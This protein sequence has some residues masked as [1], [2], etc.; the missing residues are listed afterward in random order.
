MNW[1][2]QLPLACAILGLGAA[3]Y[4][5]LWLHLRAADDG[6]YTRPRQPLDTLPLNFTL[7]AATPSE[8]SRW[9]G[10]RH[11]GT[12]AVRKQV[13]FADEVLYRYYSLESSGPVVVVYL[14][15]SSSG[16]DR[17][18]HP[19]ICMREALGVPEDASGRTLVTL[20]GQSRQAQRF[21]FVPGSGRQVMIYYWH[22]TLP[23]C[24]AGG[25]TWIQALHRRRKVSPPSVT[26]QVSTDA[27]PDQ[28][29]AVEKGFLPALDAA[30]RTD[31]LPEGTTVG[32]DRLPIVLLR[33]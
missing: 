12:E 27:T 8:S 23:A 17:K 11:P 20:A 24:D 10:A 16:E 14:A 25:L 1:Q 22:Y 30:L 3:V 18:H 9:M 4:L 7:S 6:A 2:R 13:P 33:H 21:R 15:Y 5:P 28:L 29:P 31:V 32:C 26:V 19:E